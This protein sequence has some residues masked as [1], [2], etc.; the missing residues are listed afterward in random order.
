VNKTKIEYADYTWNPVTG[1]T[2]GCSYCY[3]RRLA[4]GRLRNIYLANTDVAPGR[5][6]SDP[7]SPRFWTDRLHSPRKNNNES[8]IFVCDMGDLFDPHVPNLWIQAVI[9]EATF[10]WWH[11]FQFLTKQPARAAE[12]TFPPNAW[13]GTTIELDNWESF[14]RLLDLENID[15]NTLFVSVEPMLG[16][17]PYLPA[18]TAWLIIGAMT[19]PGAIRPEPE[20]VE[21]LLGHAD[22][23]G[24]PV[25]LKDNL[26]WAEKRRE[27]PR[28]IEQ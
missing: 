9:N 28:G 19:G 27:W 2:K 7:F 21:N 5:D 14:N 25:F 18:R 8:K 16:P 4:Q 26:H 1:C 13:V 3:A 22:K 23:Y 24:I 6:P 10:C 12:F 11:T 17:I 15:A 20:W